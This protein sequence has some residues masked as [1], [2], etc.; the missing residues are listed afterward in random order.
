[1]ALHELH[2]FSESEIEK[3]PRKR[4]VYVLFQ[5]E[6]PIRADGAANL[7]EALSRAKAEFPQASHFSVEALDT[8]DAM[9]QRLHKVR[10][11]LHLVRAVGFVGKRR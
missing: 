2:P 3:L 6:A 10:E 1:M 8:V 11:E 5:I 7:H 9:N 4:G